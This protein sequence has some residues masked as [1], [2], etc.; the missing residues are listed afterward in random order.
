MTSAAHPEDPGS[1]PR[2]S[3]PIRLLRALRRM[4]A[5]QVALWERWARAQRPWEADWLH[6]ERDA[7][8]EWYLEGEVAPPRPRRRG[9]DLAD[10]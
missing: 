5:D 6:W 1:P 8:G 10:N 3:W 7:D 2:P 4:N 9:P